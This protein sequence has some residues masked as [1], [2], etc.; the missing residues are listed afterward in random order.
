[1]YTIHLPDPLAKRVFDR[2]LAENGRLAFEDAACDLIAQ[3]LD[4]PEAPA[5]T[6]PAETVPVDTA[7]LPYQSRH[8]NGMFHLQAKVSPALGAA[9]KKAAAAAGLTRSEWVHARVSEAIRPSAAEVPATQARFVSD[10]SEVRT[11]RLFCDIDEQSMKAVSALAAASNRQIGTWTR[12]VVEQAIGRRPKASNRKTLATLI[13][14]AD[15]D[16]KARLAAAAE[17]DGV[18][19]FAW[20]GKAV[21]D[22]IDSP[23]PPVGAYTDQNGGAPMSDQIACA[24][25]R[26]AV[27]RLDR[28]AKTSGR[29]RSA[30]IRDA[31]TVRLAPAADPADP[32]DNGDP[33]PQVISAGMWHPAAVAPPAQPGD[34]H[35]LLSAAV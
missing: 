10:P 3:A 25:P 7:T 30:W 15:S 29:T 27:D 24:I 13:I 32:A 33:E 19:P 35:P 8:G 12:D 26:K 23:E 17:E 11:V 20:M 2:V 4:F 18:K 34:A 5:E 9:V 22:A 21:L 14:K 28:L 31:M 6:V 16:L 1:M